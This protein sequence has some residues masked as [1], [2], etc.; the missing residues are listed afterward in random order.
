MVNGIYESCLQAYNML[1]EVHAV[2]SFLQSGN[3]ILILLRSEHVSTYK[4]K[5]GGVSGVIDEDRTADEQALLEIV[6]ETGLSEQDI[7]LIKKGKPF[8]F[9]D[10][11]L[12]LRKVIYPYLFH[13]K[14]RSKIRI[15]WEHE[16]LRWI[17][18]EELGKLDTMP[19]L[20]E[21]AAE[22]ISMQKDIE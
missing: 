15:D 3:E 12:H 7:V 22:V 18:P 13:V 1:K 6:E 10:E 8:V 11:M 5:W 20:K 9:D 17:R 21:T 19:K 2:T 16:E 14:D 4:G